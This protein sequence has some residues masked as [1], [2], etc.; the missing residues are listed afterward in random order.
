MTKPKYLT[1]DSAAINEF[2]DRFDVR[3]RLTPDMT[4]MAGLLTH[5]D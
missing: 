4:P 2:I 3:C 5:R 1:G